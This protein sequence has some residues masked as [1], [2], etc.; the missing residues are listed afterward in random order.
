M[1]ELL[2]DGVLDIMI[3]ALRTDVS[4]GL[5]Q[6]PLFEDRLIVVARAGHLL[7]DT[8]RRSTCCDAISGSSVRWPPIA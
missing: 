6:R 1:V 7:S 3:G 5:E 8:R 2:T 4:M